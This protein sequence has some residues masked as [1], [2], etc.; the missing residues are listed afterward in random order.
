MEVLC[1]FICLALVIAFMISGIAGCLGLSSACINQIGK[2]EPA[3]PKSSPAPNVVRCKCGPRDTP[4]ERVRR[5]VITHLLELGFNKT[6]L[7]S[8]FLVQMGSSTRYIDIA[9]FPDGRVHHQDNVWLVVEC[10]REDLRPGLRDKG[11]LQLKSYLAVCPNALYGL[12]TTSEHH[13]ILKRKFNGHR[14]SWLTLS[15]LPDFHQE[16]FNECLHSPRQDRNPGR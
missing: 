7:H 13:V 9:V 14:L 11:V 2:L 15:E 6:Q 3:P 16:L 10:K 8:E 1:F 12:F 4:E 5:A